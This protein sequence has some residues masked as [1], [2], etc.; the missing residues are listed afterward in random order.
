MNTFSKDTPLCIAIHAIGGQGGGVVSSW[1]V[2]LAQAQ[3]WV[4]QATSVP[5]V[6]QRTG[7]TI[8]Y[9]EIMRSGETPSVMGLMP[10][11]GQ[12]DLVVAAE[13]M[14]VGRAIQRGF[15]SPDRTTLIGSTH[16]GYSVAEKSVPGNGIRDADAIEAAALASAKR[17]LRADLGAVANR[18]NSVISASLLGAIAASKALPFPRAA[19]EDVIKQAG[20]GVTSSLAAFGAAYDL[21]AQT[22]QPKE[23]THLVATPQM[24]G[25][26]KQ[27][28]QGFARLQK[29]VTDDFPDLVHPMALAGLKRVV[30]FQDVAYGG[31]YLDHLSQFLP[32]DTDA[33]LAPQMAKYIAQAMAY[34]DTIRVADLKIRAARFERIRAQVNTQN[35]EILTL[36]EF[37]H[38]RVEEM[39]GLLPNAL[40]D[41]AILR[42]FLSLFAGGKRIR[43]DTIRGFVMLYLLSGLR[44]WRRSL[45]RHHQEMASL[46][47]WLQ[48]VQK[49]ASSNLPLAVEIAKCRRLVKGYG[50]THMRS[51]SKY[52]KVIAALPSLKSRDDAA[53]WLQRLRH[54]AL[55]DVDGTAL[56]GALATVQSFTTGV[57]IAGLLLGV[58][59]VQDSQNI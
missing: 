59:D 17:F 3:G 4:V 28:Q 21:F 9:L 58:V 50:D 24:S 31:E 39:A 10:S 29:R 49:T 46:Q 26:S 18:H 40:A 56:D 8:Y 23:T 51:T 45:R 14:E 12:V 19:F 30:D 25:G 1:L 38:P 33:T 34:N 16:R 6:A 55:Q 15:V 42:G 52:A 5:G 41:N 11:P 7:A 22:D 43:T 27:Q 53:D 20:I 44:R 2:A 48:L 35:G 54:A 57:E 36:T 32:L 13:W 47:D 37:I